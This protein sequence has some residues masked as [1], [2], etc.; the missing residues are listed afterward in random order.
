METIIT[1]LKVQ[2][3]SGKRLELTAQEARE[4]H[5]ELSKLF[6]L[7]EPTPPVLLPTIWPSMPIVVPCVEPYSPF[8]PYWEVTYGTDTREPS[9]GVSNTTLY[10]EQNEKRN[11]P[12][13]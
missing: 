11:P 12:T 13:T 10:I 2:L 1:D 8:P 7:A 6:Q 9:C 5:A 4:L 3:A